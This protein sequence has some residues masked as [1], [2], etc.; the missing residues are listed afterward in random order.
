[1][2]PE[3][4][5]PLITI[6]LAPILLLLFGSF[7]LAIS[8]DNASFFIV[9]VLIAASLSGVTIYYDN[10]QMEEYSKLLDE[11]DSQS[12]K[13]I[14]SSDCDVLPELYNQEFWNSYKEKIK[15][16]YIFD[17][18]AEKEQLELMR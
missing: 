7:I 13:I 17:C 10:L 9:G 11:Y 12:Q 14:E 18:V 6:I 15:S 16:K 3:M 4:P 2:I 5:I 8:R 1:M